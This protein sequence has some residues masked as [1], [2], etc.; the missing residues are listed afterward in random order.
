MSAAQDD[1]P[2]ASA[3]VTTLLAPGDIVDGRYRITSFLAGGGM[4]S[5]YRAT[6]M[7]LEQVVAIKVISPLIHALPGMAQRFLREARAATRMK[8]EHVAHVSDVGTMPDGAP[9]LVMEYLDGSDLEAILEKGD[10]IPVEDAVDYVLQACEALAE[11]HGLGIVHRDLK[12][13]NLVLT[14]GADGLACIKLIDFG[15]SQTDTPLAA[16]E[17]LALTSPDTVMGSPRYMSPEQMEAASK[18]DAR[19]DIY[20]L[21]AVLYELLTRKVPNDGET[22]NAIY[23]AATLGPPDA[24]STLRAEVPRELDEVVLR[25]LRTDP[26]ERYPDAAELATALAPFG[27][28]GSGTRAMLVGRVLDATCARAHRGGQKAPRLARGAGVRGGRRVSSSAHS[29]HKRRVKRGA[30]ALA[31]LSVVVVAA[32][33][34][35]LHAEGRVNGAALVARTTPAAHVAPSPAVVIAPALVRSP[36]PAPPPPATVRAPSVNMAYVPRAARATSDPR[37]ATA[38]QGPARRAPVTDERTLFED[39]K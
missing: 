20:G 16:N 27:P 17:L 5:V 15:I 33:G 21:G 7:V 12:P 9:Y 28:A 29:L 35:A 31:L 10:E 14:C 19:S 2:L 6:H 34:R 37:E 26:A 23:A 38:V 22:V 13:A 8:S 25:C 36:P 1:L 39:R 32:G 4:S 11:V 18:A 24:P 30:L 3:P